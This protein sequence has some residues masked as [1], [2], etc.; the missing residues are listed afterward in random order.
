MK[1]ISAILVFALSL[2]L[3]SQTP[4]DSAREVRDLQTRLDEVERRQS[5]T[6]AERNREIA[7]LKA[8]ED[9]RLLRLPLDPDIQNAVKR[10]FQTIYG[11]NKIRPEVQSKIFN[12]F[13]IKMAKIQEQRNLSKAQEPLNR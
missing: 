4:P 8:A 12:D 3:A 2:P 6:E 7:R 1:S 10:Q 13:R 9:E 5:D 11:N